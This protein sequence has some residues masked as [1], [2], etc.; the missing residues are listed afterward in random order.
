[1]H[2]LVNVLRYAHM[3]SAAVAT[4]APGAAVAGGEA[5]AVGGGLAGGGGSSGGGA[6]AEGAG[7]A[8]A[9][10][11]A[12]G[13]SSGGDGDRPQMLTED[14]MD[15]LKVRLDFEIEWLIS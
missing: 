4:D 6:A 11:Q 15:L 1:M 9:A 12:G 5:A 7:A 13:G 8:P 10:E 14:G 3:L 2:S